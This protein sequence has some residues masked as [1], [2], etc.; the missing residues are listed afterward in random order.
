MQKIIDV[1]MNSNACRVELTK[2]LLSW[3]NLTELKSMQS[4]W[5]KQEK[6][7]F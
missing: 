5:K 6:G 3:K 1:D 4:N 2:F 7:G